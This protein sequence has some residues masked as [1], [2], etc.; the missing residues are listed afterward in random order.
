L[1]IHRFVERTDHTERAKCVPSLLRRDPHPVPSDEAAVAENIT[2]PRKIPHSE[3]R[4]RRKP[5]D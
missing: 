5:A 1:P 4:G 3:A 2:A